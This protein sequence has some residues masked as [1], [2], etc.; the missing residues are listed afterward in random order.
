MMEVNDKDRWAEWP[1]LVSFYSCVLVEHLSEVLQGKLH[2]GK[3]LEAPQTP[4]GW[5]RPR[6]WACRC[7]S[8]ARVPAGGSAYTS[9]AEWTW[10]RP[11]HCVRNAGN[12][13]ETRNKRIQSDQSVWVHDTSGRVRVR[14]A[15]DRSPRPCWTCSSTLQPPCTHTSR[16]RG[17]LRSRGRWARSRP[18]PRQWGTGRTGPFAGQ[19]WTQSGGRTRTQSTVLPTHFPS[20]L[21]QA[22]CSLTESGYL[23]PD[24]EWLST[25]WLRVATYSLTESGYLQPDWEWLP[26]AWLRVA[27]YSLTESDY[28]QPDWEW[29]PTAWLRVA[30]YSLTESG[31][32]QSDWEWLSTAWLRVAIYSLTES[33]YLQPDWEWL[34]TAWLRVAIYSLTESGYLQPDWEWLPTAWLRVA[35]YGLT[36]SGYLRPDWEWLSTAWLRVATYVLT[37]S[38]YL[39]PDWEWLPTAW[40]RVATYSLT[41]SGYLY[42]R[43]KE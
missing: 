24:W 9:A 39:Q 12:T 42:P 29:L 35:T 11:S 15:P 14:Y 31:Y 5:P 37:E 27:I 6:R 10:A 3:E 34:P 38:G 16:P 21:S 36:E 40:L 20:T 26:T 13:P 8:S 7:T 25:A 32:L 43:L 17:R 18:G 4:A 33:G 22:I 1:V 30:T 28:L 2:A 19:W 23:Q 41:E